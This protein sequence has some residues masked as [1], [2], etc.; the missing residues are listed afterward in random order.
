LLR[1][2]GGST[3]RTRGCAYLKRVVELWSGAEPAFS[4]LEARA[5]S[6]LRRC[7]P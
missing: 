7:A 3:E 2:D 4:A 6:L 5:D 1:P